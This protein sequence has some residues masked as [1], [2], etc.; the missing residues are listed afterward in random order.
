MIFSKL[1]SI[2]SSNNIP[3]LLSNTP[4]TLTED[5][6]Y[7]EKKYYTLSSLKNE[8]LDPKDSKELI[9]SYYRNISK[10]TDRSYI[11]DNGYSFDLFVICSKKIGREF[12]KT[13]SLYANELESEKET[14]LQ[15]L[16]GQ[17]YILLE[18]IDSNDK[19]DIKIVQVVKGDIVH[20]PKEFSFTLINS[21]NMEN[22]NVLALRSSNTSYKEKVLENTC[23]SSLY[24]TKNGFVR[25][26]NARPDYS[27]EE[28]KGSLVDDL[29]IN[30]QKGIYK[31]FLEFSEKYNF[32][33]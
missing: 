3:F 19:K 16:S 32:L 28:L 30:I 22:L 23:G 1:K 8:L 2:L 11:N 29:N 21:G 14:A 5:A 24:Y 20:V 13:C 10:N 25:N 15:V 9:F 7:D 12:S 31:D 18:T 26:S 17:G 33:K 4:L 6:R 27:L